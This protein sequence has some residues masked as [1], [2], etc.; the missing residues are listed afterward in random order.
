MEDQG[1]VVNGSQGTEKAVQMV[2]GHLKAVPVRPSGGRQFL[3]VPM[4]DEIRDDDPA[5]ARQGRDDVAPQV[6]RGG[7]SMQQD[8]RWT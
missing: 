6:A 3:G 2:V 7:V 5:A 1:D 4:T 8:H